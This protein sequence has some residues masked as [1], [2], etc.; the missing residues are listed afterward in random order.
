MSKTLVASACL[1]VCLAFA[2]GAAAG[3][4]IG[5]AEDATKYAPD[6]GAALFDEMNKLGTTTNRMAVFWDS[7]RADDD[8][9]LRLPP[10]LGAGRDR[11]RD[12]GRVRRLPA[13]ARDGHLGRRP[14]LLRLHRR[15]R[16][17]VPAGDQDH[18]RQR[19]EPAALLAADL[20]RL[21]EA[22]RPRGDGGRA[23]PLLRR[24]EGGQSRDRRDRRR[25][26]AARQRRPERDQQRLDLTRSLHRRA[27]QGLQGERAH[28][29]ALRRVGVALLPERQHRSRSPRAIRGRRQAA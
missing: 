8:P 22:R 2:G 18:R 29:A 15:G 12:P 24:A 11:P 20:R 26:L 13:Q 10:A 23:R 1:F 6:G 28:E 9:G 25:P 17:R 19:A 4:K 14:G 21:R 7:E 3:P 27:R 5:F 16:A